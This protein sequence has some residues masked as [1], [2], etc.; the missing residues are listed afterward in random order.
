MSLTVRS[1]SQD[2]ADVWDAFCKD[3]LQATLL[4]TRRFLSYHGE[5]FVDCS[6]IIEDEGKWVGLF[7]AALSLSDNRLVVS[8]PGVTYGGVIHQG[9][10]RGERMIEALTLMKQHYASL[11]LV[12]LLYKAVPTFYH[13]APAQ[14]DLYA[15]FRLFAKRTRC[16]IS[17]TIDLQH[18]LSASERRRRSLK[19]AVKAG[20]AI[21]EGGQYLQALWDVLFENL[22]RKHGLS[23]VHKLE[24]IQLLAERF[25]ENIRCVCGE[26]NSKVEAGTLIFITPTTYHAQYIASSE[27]GYDVSA[28]DAIF[29]HCIQAAQQNGRRWFDFGV[30]TEDSG[31]ILNDGLYRFKSEFGSGGTVH[32]FFELNLQE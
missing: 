14:D 26:V 18:R 8:H 20:V 15:L 24:E 10:L 30:S 32:E 21:V 4:H 22:E 3:A 9:I 17:S 13:Q 29:E 2:D 11:G 25:P 31:L 5:R 7:P 16:D 27:T 1:Y 12:K 23:P 28:L 6:L 19:K